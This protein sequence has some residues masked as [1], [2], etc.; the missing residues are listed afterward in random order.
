MDM[1][2]YISLKK[3]SL[4]MKDMIGIGLIP[5]VTELQTVILSLEIQSLVI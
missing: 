3:M 2:I 1:M 4:V 5:M